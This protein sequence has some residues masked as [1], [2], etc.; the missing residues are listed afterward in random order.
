M[1]K[2]I[3]RVVINVKEIIDDLEN[4]MQI[5]RCRREMNFLKGIH[6]IM[7]GIHIKRI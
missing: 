5:L 3:V 6:K 7:F 1:Y 2:A 4:L